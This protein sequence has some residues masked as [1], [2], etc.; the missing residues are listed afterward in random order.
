MSHTFFHA[1]KVPQPSDHKKTKTKAA[2]EDFPAAGQDATGRP[3]E[4]QCGHLGQVAQE[5]HQHDQEQP[6]PG[7]EESGDGP[8]SR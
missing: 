4:H 5:E 2:K 7:A 3:D 1:D 8:H 6:G